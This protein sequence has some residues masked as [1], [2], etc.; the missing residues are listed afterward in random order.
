[1]RTRAANKGGPQP[2]LRKSYPFWTPKTNPLRTSFA[3][4]CLNHS[5]F[6]GCYEI[7]EQVSNNWTLSDIPNLSSQTER[8][9]RGL[10]EASPR[11]RLGGKTYW[12]R[13]KARRTGTRNYIILLLESQHGSTPNEFGTLPP[14]QNFRPQLAQR[15]GLKAGFEASGLWR[16]W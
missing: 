15:N 12:H 14:Y 7:D 6:P 16:L 11:P 4:A 8:G 9:W 5:I 2:R 13:D 10:A 1:M 3:S